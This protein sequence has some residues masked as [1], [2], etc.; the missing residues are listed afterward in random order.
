ME[1]EFVQN[2]ALLAVAIVTALIGVFKYIKT[3]AT[4]SDKTPAAD[5]QVMAASFID[6]RVIRE[7]TD[8]LRNHMDEYARQT[9]NMN[10]TRQDLISALEESTDAILSNTDAAVNMLRFLKR[11]DYQSDIEEADNR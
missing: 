5:Q 4:K 3:E 8:T 9:R 6:S 10:K 1:G 11:R 7:L 2:A